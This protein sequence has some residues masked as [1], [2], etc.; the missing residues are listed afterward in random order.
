[1]P[2]LLGKE[3]TRG[4]STA[5]RTVSVHWEIDHGPHACPHHAMNMVSFW[6]LGNEKSQSIW[7]Y[8]KKVW[9]GP[10]PP[11]SGMA[12]PTGLI[13]VT[14]PG[15]RCP[16]A[17]VPSLGRMPRPWKRRLCQ[18]TRPVVPTVP[19]RRWGWKIRLVSFS[20]LLGSAPSTC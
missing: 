9:A 17:A 19:G 6:N 20:A 10:A 2:R 1:M 15:A 14:S 13:G 4:H 8:S 16:L 5:L 3:T 12:S 11:S 7:R 18:A